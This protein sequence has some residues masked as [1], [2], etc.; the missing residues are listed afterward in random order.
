MAAVAAAHAATVSFRRESHQSLSRNRQG[1]HDDFEAARDDVLH[2]AEGDGL[3]KSASQKRIS[4]ADEYERSLKESREARARPLPPSSCFQRF[5]VAARRMYVAREAQ[6]GVAMLIA[7]NFLISSVEAQMAESMTPQAIS[8]F[9]LLEYVFAILFTLELTWNMLAFWFAE[10][11]SSGWNVF[12]V[13]IVT[14]T[15]ISLA[16]T[17]LPGISVL[18]LFRAFRVFR[19]FK[20]IESLRNIIEGVLQSMPGVANAFAVLGILMGIWSIIGVEFYRTD[21]EEEFGTFTQVRRAD[22]EEPC[23]VPGL[24]LRLTCSP[25][26]MFTMW[27]IMTL[28]SWASGIARPLIYKSSQQSSYTAPP[29]FISYTFLAAIV[30]TNVVIAILLD[31]VRAP[32]AAG[33]QRRAQSSALTA[34][35]PALHAVPQGHREGQGGA[36]GSRGAGAGE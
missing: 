7:A 9:Y 3:T 32:H 5:R 2:L 20:R 28:D 4:V 22:H 16:F 18:R 6:T 1:S 11:W 30:M 31:N 21:A 13:L 19:L 34:F 25:Q 12:D 8:V 23:V 36:G 33:V 35:P 24:T 29:F 10:F 27:Q 14:I 17:S 15:W 26:A